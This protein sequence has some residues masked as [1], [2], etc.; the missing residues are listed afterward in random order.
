LIV[1]EIQ[2]GFGRTGKMFCHEDAGIEADLITMAKGIAGGFPLSAVVGKSEFMDAPLP[3]GLGGTYGGSPIACAAALAVLEQIE[4]QQLVARAQHIGER[5]EH[6]LGQL[7]G[8][9]PQH[10]S[11]VRIAGAMIAIELCKNGDPEQANTELTQALIANAP[12]YGLVLLAC[13]FYGNV[14]R[15]LPALTIE[16]DILDEG[17]Q[18]FAKMFAALAK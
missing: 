12:D 14:L 5:F 11:E 3:G 7:K 2:S 17:M 10:I 4:Q 16:D 18:Q 1:D 13:G 6:Y 9:Y 15:F 8:D